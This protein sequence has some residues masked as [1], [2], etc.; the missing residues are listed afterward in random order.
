MQTPQSRAGLAS[1]V[2][3]PPPS[4]AEALVQVGATETRYY[5]AGRG[6][7]VLVLSRA[8]SAGSRA[9]LFAE[10]SRHHCAIAP[11]LPRTPGDGAV[12]APSGDVAAW[13]RDVIDGLGLERPGL[14]VDEELA[15][16][17]LELAL[18]D[19]ERVR[20]LVVLRGG[21]AGGER[22]P[23]RVEAAVEPSKRRILLLHGRRVAE[24]G[25]LPPEWSAE[26]LRFLAGEP[27][28]VGMVQS[29]PAR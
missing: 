24:G 20:D 29:C 27:A 25:A 17:A 1:Q 19:P 6:T 2:A 3:P 8:P 12:G 28:Q 15:L 4:V 7:P 16:D 5:R 9:P 13:L 10:L 21:S 22:Q 26:L 14:V 11:E 18:G 23:T